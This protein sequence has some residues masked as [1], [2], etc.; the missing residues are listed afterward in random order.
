ME[1]RTGVTP[2]REEGLEEARAGARPTHGLRIAL[3]GLNYLPE[4]TG[5]APYTTGVAR[6][7]AA[8]GHEVSVVTGMPHY[9]A[10]KRHPDYPGVVRHEDD[11]GVDVTRVW[12]PVPRN[13]L[14]A[15]RVG[16]EAGFAL[17][18]AAALTHHRRT[19]PRPDVVVAVSPALLSV[20]AALAHGRAVRAP[21]GVVV[22]DVYSRTAVSTDAGGGTALRVA[23]ELE[24]RLLR[25]ATGVALAHERFRRPVTALGVPADNLTV[26]PN[27]THVTRADP[28]AG[29]AV[30]ARRGWDTRTPVVLHAGNMGAKQHL[31]NVLDTARLAADSG[32]P[33]RF[34]LLG[35]GARRRALQARAGDLANVEFIDPVSDEEFPAHLAAADVL[36]LNEVPGLHDMCAPSKLT[37]Y[38][39]A[40]RPVL[41]ATHDDSAA[42]AELATS[43][44]G[45]RVDPA[46]PEDLLTGLQRLRE[47]PDL[48]ADLAAAG[49][50]Y[51]AEQLAAGPAITAYDRW[52]R[53]IGDTPWN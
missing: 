41:A 12:H 3:V 15:G 43:R 39:A 47:H 6:G 8:L 7:L 37:S 24:G 40:G 30:R 34:V 16:L 13:P 11:G 31:E 26:L 42:A 51:A 44:A 1:R 18:A 50:R 10:W 9:P 53:D 32:L 33:H 45:L 17:G 36:L 2:A 20:A 49:P 25:R 29:D 22:Q 5:I 14:G 52:I 35:D 4:P 28:A 46:R 27:W 23:A 21:V 48:A 19:R 38:F